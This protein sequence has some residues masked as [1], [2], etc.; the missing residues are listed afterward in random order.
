MSYY[1]RR[2]RHAAAIIAAIA[3]GRASR[4][5]QQHPRRAAVRPRRSPSGSCEALPRRPAA[6]P[7]S[8]RRPRSMRA[9]SGCRN[10]AARFLAAIKRSSGRSTVVFIR[11]SIFPY[12]RENNHRALLHQSH[13]IGIKAQSQTFQAAAAKSREKMSLAGEAERVVSQRSGPS[14]AV[15]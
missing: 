8:A 10:S 7:S 3:A 11:E 14:G 12:S 6:R 9:R 2:Q 4:P 5:G 1:L 15:R 13:E